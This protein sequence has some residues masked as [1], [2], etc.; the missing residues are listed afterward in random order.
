MENRGSNLN[1]FEGKLDEEV[2]V[3]AKS[4]NIRA[5]EYLINKYEN[6]VKAKAKS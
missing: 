3:E 4:G 2:V 5:Q 1:V 6:F